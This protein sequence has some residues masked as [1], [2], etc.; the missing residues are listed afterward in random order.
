MLLINDLNI[1]IRDF[2]IIDNVSI[3]EVGFLET[4]D[5]LTGEEKALGSYLFT[6]RNV[7]FVDIPANVDIQKNDSDISIP[8]VNC[9][10]GKINV[11]T[12]EKTISPINMGAIEV[13]SIIINTTTDENRQYRGLYY[14]DYINLNY[15]Y[16]FFTK[17]YD[18]K[19]KSIEHIFTG[20]CY[21]RI[22]KSSKKVSYDSCLIELFFNNV[23]PLIKNYLSMYYSI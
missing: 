15:R 7:P 10:L 13:Y 19:G 18:K 22:E 12:N 1:G 11:N 14:T 2:D 20:Y 16:D 5:L 3:G 17:I 23:V 6:L 21:S 9:I 4:I 8:E